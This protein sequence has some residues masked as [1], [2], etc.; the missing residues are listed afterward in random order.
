MPNSDPPLARTYWV[1]EGK[2]LAGAYPGHADAVKHL[3]R[4]EGLFNAGMRTF[5]SLMEKH[6]SNNDGQPFRPYAESLTLLAPATERVDTLRFPI[7]D[8]R[9]PSPLQMTDILDAIDESVADSRPVFLH[10]FGGIGRTGTVVC[11]WLL[12]HGY[13]TVGNVFEV[14]RKLRKADR[15]RATWN[16]PENDE[17]RSF[18]LDWNETRALPPEVTPDKATD[19]FTKLTGFQETN[20][21]VVKAGLRVEGNR[22]K[23]LVNGREFKCGNLEL[24]TLDELRS[25][26]MEIRHE[27]RVNK[28]S[29]TIANVEDLLQDRHNS[30]ALFQVASQFNLLEMIGPN[31]TP[32][33]GVTRYQFDG[34]QGPA[35]AIACGASTIYRNYF[36]N[37]D[38]QLGQSSQR[39]I[40]CLSSI[41]AVLGNRN[42]ELWKMQNGYCF[43]TEDGLQTIFRKLGSMSESKLNAIR[44]QLRIGIHW[45]AEVTLNGDGH[46][47]SQVFCSAVPISYSDSK[48]TLTHWEPFARL[49]LEAAYEATLAAGVLNAYRTGKN[50]VFLTLLGG[51]VFNNPMQWIIESLE[52]A[53]N[54]FHNCD[55]DIRIVSFGVSRPEVAE[56]VSKMN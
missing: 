27:S 7:P 49:I 22:L 19:W 45:D 26:V 20:S 55:L 30:G 24:P 5:I 12:R 15:E 31:I 3:Q 11:C 10:C 52:R 2:F 51:G 35:C 13:A 47:V 48:L 21:S 33:M 44:S 6:E 46:S 38:G 56:L 40:D 54:L 17:Q 14:L 50:I 9:I 53:L 16:S 36:V 1:V 34:T 41:G 23:S 4:V 28:V 29:E 43:P 37:L 25:K 8:T 18:V 39:Q 32:E 42:A